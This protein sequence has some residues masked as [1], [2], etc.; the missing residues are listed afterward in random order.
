MKTIR[1]IGT[2]AV[3]AVVAAGCEDITNPIQEQ[4]QLVGPYVQFVGETGIAPPEATFPVVFRLPTA[5][6]ED[7]I[8]QYTFGG[9]AVF[10]EDYVIVDRAGNIRTDVTA[11]GGTAT[12][13]YDFDDTSFP[14]DTLFVRTT[15]DAVD[16]RTLQVRIVD[17]ASVTG[18]EVLPG[19][20]EAHRVF[21]L[22]IEGFVDIPTGTYAGVKTGFGGEAATTVTV[23]KPAGGIMVAGTPYDFEISDFGALLFGV[24]VPWAF[25][26]TS[27]GTVIAPSASHVYNV[28][29]VVTGTYN[30]TTNRLILDVVYSPTISWRT[31]GVL[32]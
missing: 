11:A 16:G 18:R 6:E 19:I 9:D 28:D 17:A 24:P 3:A 31:N 7:V 12:I 20:I 22:S 30:F 21:N 26:V 27:G 32:R 14:Q 13:R 10:G 5:L 1:I 4:G 29:S 25:N 15:F 2:L 23:T 8:V